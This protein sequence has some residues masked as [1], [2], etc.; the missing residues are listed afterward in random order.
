M[1]SFRMVSNSD[2]S[3]IEFRN[4]DVN[5]DGNERASGRARQMKKTQQKDMDDIYVYVCICYT[6]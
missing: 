1:L 4:G 6:W 2:E 3:S 5:G